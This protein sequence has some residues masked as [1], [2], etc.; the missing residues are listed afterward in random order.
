MLDMLEITGKFLP[1]G[2]TQST[3]SMNER[4]PDQL[5]NTWKPKD[6]NHRKHDPGWTILRKA[7]DR[8][9]HELRLE[10]N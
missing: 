9:E 2:P 3:G 8:W 10:Q 7:Q 5:T 6:V 4:L 1:H